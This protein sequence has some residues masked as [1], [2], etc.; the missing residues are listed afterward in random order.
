MGRRPVELKGSLP[1]SIDRLPGNRELVVVLE[2]GG[3]LRLTALPTDRKRKRGE[4]LPEL[5]FDLREVWD[6]SGVDDDDDWVNDEDRPSQRRF[7]GASDLKWLVDQALSR[8][9]VLRVEETDEEK[10]KH[11]MKWNFYAILKDLFGYEH[12]D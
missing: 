7:R 1:R 3:V 8:L 6:E 9:A 12:G 4:K 11:R 2:E 5:V 10:W